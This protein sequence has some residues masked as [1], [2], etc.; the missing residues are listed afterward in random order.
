MCSLAS[1]AGANSET[2]AILSSSPSVR[3]AG[4][5]AAGIGV[6]SSGL[7]GLTIV[8]PLVATTPWLAFAIVFFGLCLVLAGLILSW[9]SS[10]LMSSVALVVAGVLWP[11][12]WIDSWGG[13]PRPLIALY[14]P[15]LAIVLG[16]YAMYRYPDPVLLRDKDRRWLAIL[17]A[18]I[19]IGRTLVVVTS[20]PSWYD[21][22]QSS[23]WPN[24]IEDRQ[25]YDTVLALSHTGNAILALAFLIAWIERTKKAT[26]LPR[27]FAWP[28]AAAGVIAGVTQIISSLISGGFKGSG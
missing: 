7:W 13:G 16:A 8:W 1:E 3:Q 21:E 5:L 22:P 19:I 25:V 23:W 17:I 2:T 20:R 12:G 24:V 10:Q 6:V 28:P 26:R 4:V 15:P 18:W 9:E 27:S 14:A 11:L